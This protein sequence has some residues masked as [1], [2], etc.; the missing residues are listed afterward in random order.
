MPVV[1]QL[2][3]LKM[4][5]ETWVLSLI[6][7]KGKNH[8]MLI[9]EGELPDRSDQTWFWCADL[10]PINPVEKK[11]Q[12]VNG[13][14]RIYTT[15][16]LS[17]KD[18]TIDFQMIEELFSL[19]IENNDSCKSWQINKSVAI[20]IQNE[21]IQDQKNPPQFCY[22]GAHSLLQES[23]TANF[24]KNVKRPHNCI[25]WAEEK[26]T[27]HKINLGKCSFTAL[28]DLIIAAPFLH[29]GTKGVHKPDLDKKC[30]VM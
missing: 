22:V 28:A 18:S 27:N 5:T 10:F 16:P 14:I 19:K 1:S 6:Q 23:K 25:T 8:A 21:I 24:F 9:V 11:T 15:H 29:V 30:L 4:D 26:L 17:E 7:F 20:A 3:G 13:K 12:I 2:N